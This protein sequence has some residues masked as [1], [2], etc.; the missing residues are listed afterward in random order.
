[1][2]EKILDKLKYKN[3]ALFGDNIGLSMMLKIIPSSII[4]CVVVASIRPQYIDNLRDLANKKGICLLIQPKFNTKNYNLF[5]KK[6]KNCKIDL[7]V[8]NSYSM[9]IRKDILESVNYNSINIH[10]SLLPKNRGPNPVQWSIIKGE[11]ETGATIHYMNEKFDSGDIITQKKINISVTDTWVTLLNKLQILQEKII[12]ETLPDILLGKNKRYEQNSKL[13]TINK[14]ITSKTPKINFKM[15]TDHEIYNLIRAQVKPLK[16]AYIVNN[17]I[18]IYLN[19]LIP[20][21]EVSKLRNK[22]ERN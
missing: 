8:C 10:L 17:K 15:M 16:G 12:I 7:I 5:Y 19:H 18:N 1:M 3:L 13:A 14:R 22:Y 4:K 20:L 2:E 21:T 9:L 11:T 6:F